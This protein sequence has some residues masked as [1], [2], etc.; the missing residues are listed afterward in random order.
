MLARW[1]TS[2]PA[3]L[4]EDRLMPSSALLNALS[5][6]ASIAI[7]LTTF[8]CM[9]RCADHHV[10]WSLKFAVV[11]C[12]LLLANRIATIHHFTWVWLAVSALATAMGTG[13]VRLSR[14]EIGSFIAGV[15]L[16]YLNWRFFAWFN[17][18]A[19]PLRLLA[20]NTFVGT[21][22]VWLCLV[23]VLRRAKR[24]AARGAPC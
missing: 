11:I 19:G 14:L 12:G 16:L 22:L 1:F 4:F 23:A 15:L 8:W 21:V 7:V 24:D 13:R 6:T 5:L 10:A 9:P 17:G 20:C 3:Y 2:D 18:H